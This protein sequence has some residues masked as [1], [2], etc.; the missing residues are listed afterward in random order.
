MCGGKNFK[1][2]HI[3]LKGRS[4]HGRTERTSVTRGGPSGRKQRSSFGD[5]DLRKWFLL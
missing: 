3:E 2:N 5:T 4:L 1:K